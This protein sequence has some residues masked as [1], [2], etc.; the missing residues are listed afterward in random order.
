MLFH[1]IEG[2]EPKEGE[3]LET[4]GELVGQLHNVM[5]NYKG[6]LSVQGKEFFIDRFITI[7]NKKIYDKGK[8]RMFRDYGEILW[9]RVENLPRGFCHGDM[10]SGNL[11]K[12]SSGKLHLL[13]FDTSCIAFPTYDIMIMCNSTNYFE[14]DEK[15][16]SNASRTYESFLKG[17]SKYRTLS[18]NEYKAFY[19][20]IAIYNYQLQASIIEIYKLDCVDFKFLDTQ[21]DWLRRWERKITNERN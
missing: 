12:T 9:Q 13:D 10:H 21:L 4:V 16:Y 19:D 3:Q 18:S 7:L 17:Y 11:L 5:L 8:T 6:N 1:F 14:F 2:A 15:G 20:L